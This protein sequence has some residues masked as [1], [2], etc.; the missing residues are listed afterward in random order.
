MKP[1]YVFIFIPETVIRL[2]LK[3]PE[4]TVDSTKYVLIWKKG[5][6]GTVGKFKK[7][8]CEFNCVS[9]WEN[10]VT[11]DVTVD[12]RYKEITACNKVPR[13]TQNFS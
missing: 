13:Q 5:K 7:Q 4:V 10:L 2:L 11:K 8:L 3:K 9:E 6:A 1:S 12:A